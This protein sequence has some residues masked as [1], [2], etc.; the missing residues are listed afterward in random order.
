MVKQNR[1]EFIKT[2][3][4]QAAVV[5]ALS[6]LA[7]GESRKTRSKKGIPLKGPIFNQDS[8]QFF[9]DHA[10]DEING[11]VVDAWVDSLAGA[12]VGTLM[13]NTCAMRANYA[14]KVWETDWHG[15]DPNGP[16]DQPVLKYLPKDDIPGTRR[17]LDSVKKLADMGINFHER[18][19]AR[20]RKN[21]ISCWTSVR[22]NDLHDC[23]LE[24]SPLLS[25]FYKEHRHLIRVPYR[26]SSWMDRALDWS[27]REVRDH[28]MKLLREQLEMFDLDGI[29]LD[30]M[31]FGY[32][33]GIGRELEGGEI[34]T[35][36]VG[37]VRKEC[38]KAAK[39]LG[40]PVMLG[41]RV[42]ST[43]ETARNLGMDGVA[44]AK[45]GLIDLLVPTPFWA[46]CEFNM[47]MDTWRGLL[48]GTKTKL[49]GGLEILYR[50]MPGGPA[51][52]NTPE[53]AAGA[54]MAVLA[55][56]ADFVYVFNYFSW[57]YEPLRPILKAM[58]GIKTLDKLP[59][60]HA[61]TYRDVL[62]P[63]EPD[64]HQLPATGGL[65]TFRLQTGPK[66]TGRQVEVILEL[67]GE[68]SPPG[69]R[70]NGVPCGAPKS[71]N[72]KVFVFPVPEESLADRC[73][74]VE[75]TSA[76]PMTIVRVEF[77]IGSRAS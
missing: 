33:F 19:F 8:T 30:W 11:E 50:P 41:V 77:A 28:Y 12:E 37:E 43:P 67:Q 35:Q 27:H 26:A 75:V 51:D 4:G 14:S 56:G 17:R 47:P 2:S 10:A 72:G 57:I 32:H 76:K 53:L 65:S 16:D 52:G 64:G 45:A 44:W 63:G 60:H 58:A 20:C 42:P 25:T 70:V 21:G 54:A 74:V 71:E 29:E 46:T 66:P 69:V 3:L 1:R 73:H 34:L 61:I 59:R 39:R 55:G 5:A 6:P 24:D 7:H 68:A 23:D 15:Y 9:Y 40:H 38:Q 22:M 49:A 31:R 18:A 13:S 62:A 36:F 48:N